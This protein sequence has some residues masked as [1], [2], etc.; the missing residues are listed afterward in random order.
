MTRKA[1][2]LFWATLAVVAPWALLEAWRAPTWAFFPTG[3]LAGYAA[4]ITYLAIE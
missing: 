4:L 1:L 3:V 2:A